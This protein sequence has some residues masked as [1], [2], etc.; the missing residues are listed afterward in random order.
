M[1]IIP[2]DIFISINP[3]KCILREVYRVLR[4]VANTHKTQDQGNRL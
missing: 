1:I 4:R 2:V 3:E